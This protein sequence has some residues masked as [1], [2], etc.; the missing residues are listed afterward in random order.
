VVTDPWKEAP[1]D[2]TLRTDAA[3]VLDDIGRH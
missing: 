3:D 2:R 1:M